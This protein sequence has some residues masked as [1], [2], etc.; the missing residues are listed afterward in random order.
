MVRAKYA[1][2]IVDMLDPISGAK[3]YYIV[4]SF[5]I[6]QNILI[7]SLLL[8]KEQKNSKSKYNLSVAFKNVYFFLIW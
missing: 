1:E 3:F 6:I 4:R 7:F 5:E 2:I 8:L